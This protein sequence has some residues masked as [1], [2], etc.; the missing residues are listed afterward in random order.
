MKKNNNPQ[1]V[2]HGEVILYPTILPNKAVLSKETNK[3]IIAH[4]ET[5]HHHVLEAK[6]DFKIY[7]LL[8]DTYIEIPSVAEL[9][10]QK[11]GKDIHTPH[12]IAPAVYKIVI[13]K[14]FDY[15]EGIIR[16]V[17]D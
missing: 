13:K 2:R 11:T 17:R 9:W 7:T 3:E 4:S 16:Q 8:G 12:K 15:F 14:E 1:I 10:H 6:E 5:G